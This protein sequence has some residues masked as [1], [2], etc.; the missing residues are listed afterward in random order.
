MLKHSRVWCM[1]MTGRGQSIAC[2]A[3]CW[4][5]WWESMSN[6]RSN[7]RWICPGFH[8]AEI[9]LIVFWNWAVRTRVIWRELCGDDLFIMN[10]PVAAKSPFVFDQDV[11]F[12]AWINAKCNL[13]FDRPSTEALTRKQLN[14]IEWFKLSRWEF[15]SCYKLTVH[16]FPY[17]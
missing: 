7:V 5:R 8:P 13:N 6:W 1:A 16:C 9:T 12:Y 11:K 15:A 3:S 17:T 2:A 14:Y 10:S 4:R